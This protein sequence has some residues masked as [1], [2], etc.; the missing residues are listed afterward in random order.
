MVIEAEKI[1][2]CCGRGFLA[3]LDR[4][5]RKYCGPSCRKRAKAKRQA[6]VWRRGREASGAPPGVGPGALGLGQRLA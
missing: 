2:A 1:C 5:P 3:R 6:E 4:L